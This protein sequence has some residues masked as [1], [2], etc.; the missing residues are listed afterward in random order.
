LTVAYILGAIHFYLYGQKRNSPELRAW[1]I[2]AFAA[3]VL[4]RIIHELYCS[5]KGNP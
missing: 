5:I 1:S 3:G 4:A 2:P